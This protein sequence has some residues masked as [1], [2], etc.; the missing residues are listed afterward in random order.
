MVIAVFGLFIQVDRATF[1]QGYENKVTKSYYEI[2]HFCSATCRL[3]LFEH[4]HSSCARQKPDVHIA[5]CQTSKIPQYSV[6]T[7][8]NYG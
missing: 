4:F 6:F 2:D 5:I 7:K 1:N 8:T 3:V